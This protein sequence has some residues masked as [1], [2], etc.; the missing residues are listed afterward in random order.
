MNEQEYRKPIKTI[1]SENASVADYLKDVWH[2]RN[3]ILVFAK[4]E[5]KVQFVQTKL[6]LL[7]SV[8][9]PLMVLALFTFI[10]DR[11]IHIPGLNYPYPLFAFSGLIIWN[12]FSFMVNNAGSVLIANQNLIKKMYFPRIILLLSKMLIS[13]LD[14]LISFV[15]LLILL[16]AWQYPISIQF[17]FAPFF[18]FL[19]LICGT[20]IAI[21]MNALTIKHRDLHQFVPT[22]IGFVI[23]L[24]PV[25]YPVTLIP[26]EYK[27]VSYLNPIAGAIQ[28]F[29]WAV[30]SDTKP[31]LWYMPSIFASLILLYAGFIA[32]VKSETILSDYI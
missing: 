18:I 23:W 4:Q 26:D 13:L 27:I 12:N 8:L 1:T 10:F 30:L 16:L 24:T 32:F 6:N 31:S 21:W 25:F 9:R 20:A 3:L 14:V 11:V 28:G 19:S 2:F 17:V 5:F 15:I 29:R 7:W 22:L